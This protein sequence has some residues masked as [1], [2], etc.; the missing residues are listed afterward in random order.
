VGNDDLSTL[1]T[2][3]LLNMLEDTYARAKSVVNNPSAIEGEVVRRDDYDV[4]NAYSPTR[5]T[6]DDYT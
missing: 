3:D 6:Q 1:T 2:A 5:S 4:H